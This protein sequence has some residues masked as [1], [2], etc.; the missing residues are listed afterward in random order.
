MIRRKNIFVFFFVE[1]LDR[2]LGEHDYGSMIVPSSNNCEDYISMSKQ[3]N[4]HFPN[5]SIHSK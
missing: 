3:E 1:D 4:D 5:G 2:T